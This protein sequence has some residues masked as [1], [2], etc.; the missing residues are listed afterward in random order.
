MRRWLT[1][2]LH[3]DTRDHVISDLSV[4]R[5]N[6]ADAHGWYNF[7]DI[8]DDPDQYHRSI[9]KSIHRG[10]EPAMLAHFWFPR[11]AVPRAI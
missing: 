9:S 6:I 1:E 3:I 5:W 10:G 7:R 8:Y 11:L 4:P 2:Q